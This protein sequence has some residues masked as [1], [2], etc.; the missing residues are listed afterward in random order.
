MHEGIPVYLRGVLADWVRDIYPSPDDL[1][2]PD[3]LTEE[4]LLDVI[5]AILSTRTSFRRWGMR[6]RQVDWLEELLTTGGA[7]WR[8]NAAATGL[9]RRV[10][11]TIGAGSP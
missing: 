5:D 11:A 4:Q 2:D 3:T 8:L 7:G 9:E 10:E 6:D 1:P